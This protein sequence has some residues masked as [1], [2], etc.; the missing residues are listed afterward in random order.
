MHICRLE[1]VLAE[2]KTRIKSFLKSPA[3]LFLT[4]QLFYKFK[5]SD[6]LNS[7][8]NTLL[9]NEFVKKTL[10]TLEFSVLRGTYRPGVYMEV[11]KIAVGELFAFV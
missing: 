1:T 10:E 2:L 8:P 7:E 4:Q 6:P 3:G 5:N 11:R 9:E